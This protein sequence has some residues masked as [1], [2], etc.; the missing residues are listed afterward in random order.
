MSARPEIHDLQG[1][2]SNR[3]EVKRF[4]FLTRADLAVLAVIALFG[5]ASV[6]L[7]PRTAD[8]HGEDVFFADAAQSLLHHGFYGVNGNPETT[9]PPGLSFVLAGVFAVFGYGNGVSLATMAVFAVA[10]FAV[11]YEVLRRR[12]PRLVAAAICIILLSSPAYFGWATRVVA[13][14]FIYF[15]TTMTALL[16]AEEYQKASGARSRIVWGIVLS[17]TVAASLLTATSTLALLIALVAVIVVTAFKDRALGRKKLYGFLPVLLVG[18]LA[19][20]LWA[21]R[22]AAPLEWPL[23]GY[24]A[25]YVQQLKVK[26]GNYPELGMATWRDIPN[27]VITNLKAES[28]ILSQLVLRH[29]VNQTKAAMVIVP[30]LLL[31]IGWIYAMWKQGGTD[32]AGW[33]FAVYEF[34]YL[35]WPWTMETRFFLPVAPLACL[36]MWQG[37]NALIH[38]ANVRPRLAGI[39]WFPAALLITFSGVRWISI[40]GRDGA[41]D[42]PHKLV[43]LAWLFSAL[44]ALFM[45]FTGQS[46]FSAKPL[47]RI[48]KW[49]AR[50]LGSLRQT[51]GRLALLAVVSGLVL[52]G[53]VVEVRM[54]RENLTTTDTVNHVQTEVVQTMGAEVEAG[55]WLRSHTDPYAV[56]MARHWPTVHHYAQRKLV[57]FA[58]IS[59]PAVLLAGML[60]HHVDYVVVISHSTPYYLPDD[61]DCFARLLAAY[62]GKFNLVLRGADLRIFRFEGSEHPLQREGEPRD[63]SGHHG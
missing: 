56:V 7:H 13:P 51:P 36:Y 23:P 54:A 1:A 18:M 38:F 16:S 45:A 34:I 32:L 11:T 22:K 63:T 62:P 2:S 53:F 21:H 59:D 50:P 5:L 20:S 52:A 42:L 6:F 61:S 25:S 31:S 19:Q 43:L 10:G 8:F 41:S 57:W 55:T 30:I 24:P 15:F 35:L 12:A 60:K 58:P 47:Q 14:C 28:D 46:V 37:V 39:I 48:G 9:I 17:A 40:Y 27:R 44:C 33:Y 4:P 49:F 3:A 26:S 29:G